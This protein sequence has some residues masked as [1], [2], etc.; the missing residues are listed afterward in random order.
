MLIGFMRRDFSRPTSNARAAS[1]SHS[2]KGKIF[3]DFI[4]AK[5]AKDY[6]ETQKKTR[7]S[8]CEEYWITKPFFP[9]SFQSPKSKEDTRKQK[10]KQRKKKKKKKKKKKQKNKKI[11]F[12]CHTSNLERTTPQ[13][14]KLFQG[15]IGHRPIARIFFFFFL[16]F[17]F[18]FSSVGFGE[19]SF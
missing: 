3:S 9:P 1:A 6:S 10:R 16:R 5:R 14:L 8:F 2:D 13:H 15:A 19:E 11:V 17:L 7:L 12:L 4:D 18:F